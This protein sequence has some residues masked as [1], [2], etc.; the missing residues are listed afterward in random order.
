LKL[1]RPN[2]ST[3]VPASIQLDAV[4]MNSMQVSTGLWK[5]VE[6]WITRATRLRQLV[7]HKEGLG[8]IKGSQAPQ[9]GTSNPFSRGVRRSPA[10][11]WC[12]DGRPRRSSGISL[13]SRTE[14]AERYFA[15]FGVQQGMPGKAAAGRQN[16]RFHAVGRIHIVFCNVVPDAAKIANCPWGEL[17]RS[18]HR[19][20]NA[21]ICP[22]VL[23][24]LDRLIGIHKLSPFRLGKAFLNLGS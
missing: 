18:G 1:S 20:G 22:A 8:S 3:L 13:P 17:E 19:S 4:E 5:A 6:K 11:A 21:P 12:Q 23:Q 16:G 2:W 9:A 15:S 7:K 24:H 10:T 14:P